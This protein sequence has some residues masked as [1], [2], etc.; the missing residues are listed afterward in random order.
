VDV[1]VKL[2]FDSKQR[3]A[4]RLRDQYEV[5]RRLRS[6]GV[7][8]CVA[9]VLRF[10]DDSECGPCA[11]VM[12]YAGVSLTRARACFVGLRMV[13]FETTICSI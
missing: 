12:P 7:L 3:D 4:L 5:Y 10:F 8:Q 13:A 2:A 6:K 9:T 1:V 11:I